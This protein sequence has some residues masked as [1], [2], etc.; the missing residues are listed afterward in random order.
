MTITKEFAS[1][2]A[3]AFVAVAMVFSAFATPAKAQTTEDLQQMINELLAEV[4]ALQSSM[5]QG[6]TSVASGVCPYTWTRDL[7]V[8]ATGADVM[9][10][11][12]FLNA[13]VDTRVSA[14]GAGSVGAETEY[15]GPATAAAVSKFQVANRAAVL[16]PANL[17]NPTGYFGP[18]SRSAANAQCATAPV[19]E[20]D[21]DH[22]M[23]DSDDSM[24]DSSDDSDDSDDSVDMTLGGEGVLDDVEID[25]ASDD[26]VEEGENDVEIAE[27][28]VEAVD[29]DIEISRMDI[30]I[31]GGATDAWDIL[32]E[33][34]LWIDGDKVAEM[35]AS[36]EDEYKSDDV[37]LRFSGL[38][39]FVAEDEEVEITIA[40]S[41]NG[42]VDVADRGD[43]DVSVD[44]IR[45]FDADGVAET[46]TTTGDLGTDVT[47]TIV[48]EGADDEIVVKTS[49]NDPDAATLQVEDDSKSDWYNVFTFD[50]DTDDSTNDIDLEEVTV[51]LTLSSSTYALIVDDVELVIDGVTIDD[52]TASTTLAGSAD[53]VFDVDGDVTINAGDRVEAQLMVRFKSLDVTNE[54]MTVTGSVTAADTA[55]IDADGADDV[56]DLSGAATGDAHSLRT[57]GADITTDSVDADVVAG[58]SA[59]DDYGTFVIEVEVTAFEQDVFIAIAPATG[60]S[61][62]LQDGAGST[63]VTG[64]RSVTL[65][66][67]AD[68]DGTYFEITEGSTETLTLTV[69]YTPGVANTA[70]RM[71]LN[72]ISFAA[73]A[74]APTQ[75]QTTLP[76][77]DFRTDV[78]TMV[79]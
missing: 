41:I 55:A 78:V 46:D 39:L 12:Q 25:S 56:T 26:E 24:D 75:T 16:S 35:D 4:A 20:D 61:Y 53:L 79:N 38:D 48:A 49:S 59:I 60:V 6:A 76:A 65:T 2:L 72:S 43:Y 10:L 52:V 47:F 44:S 73:T 11:Q 51:S 57:A 29:G 28:T 22:S 3:V 27:V 71:L 67:T 21:A 30:A 62:T 70:A 15:Y 23:D 19:V 36:D 8:G 37:T 9:K 69:T 31:D 42:S 14:S 58:D 45:F 33:I 77:S 50:L 17:V 13:N 54:G 18:S 64:T 40:A 68:D 74:V 1:K 5:G 63:S 7:N 32:D 34:S 66:S